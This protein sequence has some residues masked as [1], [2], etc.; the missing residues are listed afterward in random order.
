[1]SDQVMNQSQSD[2]QLRE[3]CAAICEALEM[4]RAD[5]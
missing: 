1:M 2:R 3:D 5:A 4:T